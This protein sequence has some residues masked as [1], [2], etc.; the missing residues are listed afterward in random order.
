MMS[1]AHWRTVPTLAV[2]GAITITC[3]ACW[4][5]MRGATIT[6][7]HSQTKDLISHVRRADIVVAG[8]G[9]PARSSIAR[10]RL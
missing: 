8:I 5:L 2:F 10:L 4:L 9:K 7:C 6:V 1:R 3:L